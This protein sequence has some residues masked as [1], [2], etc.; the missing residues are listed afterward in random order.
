M[1]ARVPRWVF[2]CCR[3]VG[4][5]CLTWVCA[6]VCGVVMRA[7]ASTVQHTLVRTARTR[8]LD[9]TTCSDDITIIVLSFL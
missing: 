6:C 3:A 4:T 7:C 2:A 5:F 8:W 9:R 1:C